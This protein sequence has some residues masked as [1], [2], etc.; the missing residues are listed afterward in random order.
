[1]TQPYC[2]GGAHASFEYV[3]VCWAWEDGPT[4]RE[5]VVTVAAQVWQRVTTQDRIGRVNQ[6]E[7]E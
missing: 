4:R 3:C 7:R 1:M 5:S 2:L 6:S